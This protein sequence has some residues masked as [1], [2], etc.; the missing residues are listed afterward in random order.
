M[1]KIRPLAYRMRPSKIDDVI[2]QAH[3][4]GPNKPIRKMVENKQLTSLLLFGPP[5][6]GKTTIAQSIAR[7]IDIPFRSLNAVTATKKDLDAI[8]KEA[9]S[10]DSSILL[11]I[12]EIHRFTKST[13]EALLPAMEAGD[14]VIIGS[15]TNR[16][17]HS[18]PSA[19]LSRCFVFELKPLSNSEVVIGL[20]RALADKTNGLGIYDLE[21]SEDVLM[22]LAETTTGDMRFALNTLEAVVI[23][24]LNDDRLILTIEMVERFTEKKHLSYNGESTKYNLLSSLQKSVRGSDVDAS[25]YYLALLLE[26]GDLPSIHRRLLV[27]SD[28]DISLGNVNVSTHVLTAVQISERVGLPEARIPLAKAVIELCLSPKTNASYKALDAA[29]ALIKEGHSYEPPNHLKDNHYA[30]ASRLNVKG[31]KYAHD[32][33]ASRIGAWVEQQ[34]LPNEL[35]GTQFYFPKE[36]GHEKTFADMYK[37]ISHAK[38]SKKRS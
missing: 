10:S 36:A 20:K 7:D 27:I 22:F 3:L 13:L 1:T 14:I 2:G 38:K 32:F 34:Y 26:S 23:S 16:V 4:L 12:D 18:L 24:N 9:V 5:G 21:Y 30:G 11:F 35:I 6:I 31:Y 15:T 28:E 25:L 19:I 8:I 17:F 37:M 33:Q 29:I